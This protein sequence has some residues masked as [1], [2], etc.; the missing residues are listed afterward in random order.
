MARKLITISEAAR[1][2]K[3]KEQV[4]SEIINTG[5]LEVYK[6][7]RTYKIDKHEIKEWLANMSESDEEQLALR[8]TVCRFV[9]YFNIQHVKLGIEVNNKY[10][11]IAE[12]AKFAKSLKIVRDHR[13]L[14]EVVV[15]R[16]E[17]VST[18]IGKE[19]ALLHP[20]H[21]HPSKIKKPCIL[22]GKSEEGIEFDAP[23]KKGVKLIFMLLLH[24]DK[25][26]LFSLSYLSRFLMKNENR[27]NLINSDSP[28]EIYDMLTDSI[29]ANKEEK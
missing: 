27:L 16:E 3:L 24:N 10:E 19:T 6:S 23:D 12:M 15:A 8:R 13:W 26:H 4:V 5:V 18:A 2:L 22:L 9:D 11:A 28:E 25:Q 17:L 21:P 7:G 14:Y 20:R 1:F 29:L